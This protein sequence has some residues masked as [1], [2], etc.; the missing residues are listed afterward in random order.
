MDIEFIINAAIV[1]F[2][3]YSVLKRGKDVARKAEDIKKQPSGAA[4]GQ[5]T[6]TSKKTMPRQNAQKPNVLKDIFEELEKQFSP[7]PQENRTRRVKKTRSVLSE[8]AEAE[9]EIQARA[10]QTVHEI[11]TSFESIQE[12]DEFREVEYVP[13]QHQRLKIKDQELKA[14]RNSPVADLSF[15][16]PELVKGMIMSEILAA[17]LAM[18]DDY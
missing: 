17:P 13:V 3:I 2:I 6:S 18:R 12:S 9:R 16:G 8:L 10:K 4:P 14:E 1:F 5:G 15:E 7:I 11:E